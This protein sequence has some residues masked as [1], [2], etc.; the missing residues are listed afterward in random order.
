MKIG[1]WKVTEQSV[2]WGGK[3]FQRFVIGRQ[4]LLETTQPEDAEAPLYKNL[5][6]AME[7]DWLT[8]DDL[9][10]LNF[11]FVFASG[12]WQ[13]PMDYE[14]LDNTMEYQ[15]MLLDEEDDSQP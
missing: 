7:T 2:E 8:T 5:L 10:D 6:L 9:Y 14:T 11:A 3:G 4:S 12:S 1:N 13:Q 15:Y